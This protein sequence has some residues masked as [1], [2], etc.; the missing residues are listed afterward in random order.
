MTRN[1]KVLGLALVAVFAMSAMTASAAFATPEFTT[2]AGATL[3]GEEVGNVKFTV[4]GQE[5]FCTQYAYNATAPAASFASVTVNPEYIHCTGAFGVEAHVTGFGPTGCDYVLNANGTSQLVCAA[6][7]DVTV[8]IA[9]CTVHIPAQHFA[10]GITYT[11]GTDAAGKKDLLAHINISGITGT[12]TDGFLC[13]FGSSG[14]ST[15]GELEGTVTLR[16]TKPA[17]TIVDLTDHL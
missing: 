11:T 6:G 12:H 9:S 1:L 14:H 5:V 17:G 10:S 4:T 2:T 15:T 8:E 13:P 16:A 3:D 7:K